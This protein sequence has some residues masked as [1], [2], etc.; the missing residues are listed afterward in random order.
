VHI[1]DMLAQLEELNPSLLTIK[2]ELL[3]VP[4]MMSLEKL[5][6]RFRARRGYLKL[7]RF[8]GH[9]NSK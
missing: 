8:D 3:V 2:R 9:G 5:L 7:P 1:K 4:E 6:M